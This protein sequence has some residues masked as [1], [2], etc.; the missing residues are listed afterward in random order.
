[1]RWTVGLLGALL[2][3]GCYV[4]GGYGYRNQGYATTQV[5]AQPAYGAQGAPAQCGACVQ[6][7]AE[8]CNGCDDNCNGAIDE[9]CVSY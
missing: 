4:R 7:A 5:S 1:M 3:S 2:L 9:N 8:I 6:G